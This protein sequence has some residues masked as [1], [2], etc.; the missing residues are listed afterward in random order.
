[1]YY[2]TGSICTGCGLCVDTCPQN[3]IILTDS[4]AQINQEL[5]IQCG[6]CIEL[7]PAGAVHVA[8]AP[9]YTPG[10]ADGAAALNTPWNNSGRRRKEAIRMRG[11]GWFGQGGGGFGFRGASPQW[12]YTGRGRGGLPRC[13]H[14][15]LY[16]PATVAGQVPYPFY[17]G[18]PI[19]MGAPYATRTT[20]EQELDLLKSQAEMI[21]TQ[22]DSIEARM[23][24]IE[25]NM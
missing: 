8:G 18:E 11:R 16:A 19:W 25:V 7:C 6:S 20:P 12:P 15:G 23:R 9:V 17:A 13:W 2:I 22:L 1:M 24:E 4:K 3:A 5:C 21:K 14:P 10:Q